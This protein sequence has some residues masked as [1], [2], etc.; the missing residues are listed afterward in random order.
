M[1]TV[2]VNLA[3][4]AAR[5]VRARLTVI[6]LVNLAEVPVRVVRARL[7]VMILINLAGGAAPL[8]SRR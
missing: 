2:L 1:V 7:M 5:A 3:G 4:V 8:P 6:I